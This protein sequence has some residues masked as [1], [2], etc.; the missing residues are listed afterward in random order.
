MDAT[1]SPDG[2]CMGATW[3]P[4]GIQRLEGK[5]LSG[6]G[7]SISGAT[8]VLPTVWR[9]D[10]NKKPSKAWEPYWAYV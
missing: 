10:Q 3:M 5:R 4:S 9:P 8:Q 2:I 7:Q 1:E 6:M